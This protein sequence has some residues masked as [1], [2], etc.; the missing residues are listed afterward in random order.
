MKKIHIYKNGHIFFEGG[1]LSIR[2]SD[3]P[4]ETYDV[5]NISEKEFNELINAPQKTKK[6]MMK[7]IKKY[8]GKKE[9]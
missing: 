2:P 7:I 9:K 4:S 8:H 3:P 5:Q 6:E 1:A